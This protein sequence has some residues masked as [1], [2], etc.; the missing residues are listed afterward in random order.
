MDSTVP[1]SGKSALGPQP[2]RG[3][4]TNAPY[5]L[6]LFVQPRGRLERALKN[7]LADSF[8]QAFIFEDFANSVDNRLSLR[9]HFKIDPIPYF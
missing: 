3:K 8:K 5:Q 6:N 4:R 9:I 2:I 1:V 7:D